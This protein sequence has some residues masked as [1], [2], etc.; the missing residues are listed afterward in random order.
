MLAGIED[1]ADAAFA[2]VFED[3]RPGGSATGAER[4]AQPGFIL[5]A[6]DPPVGFAHLLDLDGRAHLE[7]VSVVPEHGRQGVGAALLE[8]V[9][10]VAAAGGYP[11]VTLRTFA[12]VPWNG[13]FY[14]TH[15]FIE[16]VDEPDWMVPLREAEERFGL[17]RY[18]RR[19]A[20]GRSL[21]ENQRARP[22]Q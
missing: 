21:Q 2:A 15:G 5:V 1:A 11:E 7:Q 14:A 13:P 6:G 8:E 3:W 22:S 9:C 20:M 19:I 10:R 18:G 4:A 17:S 12:D 16:L